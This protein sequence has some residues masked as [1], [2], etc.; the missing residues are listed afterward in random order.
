MDVFSF[1]PYDYVNIEEC[2]I[3]AQTEPPVYDNFIHPFQCGLKHNFT[4]ENKTKMNIK[5][6]YVKYI[7][8][9]GEFVYVLVN[10]CPFFFVL[11]Y[12]KE[13]NDNDETIIKLK[14]VRLKN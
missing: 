9:R 13:K 2:S 3:K 4:C 5:H 8:S 12:L 11:R 1:M 7:F 6:N 10:G 14:C